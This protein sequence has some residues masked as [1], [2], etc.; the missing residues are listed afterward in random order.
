MPSNRVCSSTSKNESVCGNCTSG[1]KS[2]LREVLNNITFVFPTLIFIRFLSV[3]ESKSLRV[4]CKLFILFGRMWAVLS[5]Y[6][7]GLCL[8]TGSLIRAFFRS[9][10]TA[11]EWSSTN[12]TDNGRA[13]GDG[14]GLGMVGLRHAP[15]YFT[16]KI[17]P[18]RRAP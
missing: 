17:K 10:F 1:G 9:I 4:S 11:Q 3:N 14:I 12:F 16:M 15:L 8:S 13:G 7:N 6:P 2:R 18:P 5:W